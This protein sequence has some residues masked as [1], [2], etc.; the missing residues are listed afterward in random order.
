MAEKAMS[1]FLDNIDINKD[2]NPASHIR[3]IL[4]QF[5]LDSK[6][7]ERLEDRVRILGLDV[8]EGAPCDGNREVWFWAFLKF[9]Q[10]RLFFLGTKNL[11][12]TCQSVAGF[13][14]QWA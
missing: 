14:Q 4:T 13:A 1:A 7:P 12:G 3:A 8:E 10:G 2:F 5:G 9:S 11:W 6:D